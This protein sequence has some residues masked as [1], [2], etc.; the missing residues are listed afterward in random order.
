MLISELEKIINY[1]FNNKN[2]IN[3][4]LIHSSYVSKKNNPNNLNY[5]RLEFLGD[6]VLGLI[7]AEYFFKILPNAK[8]GVLN[9]YFQKS[10]NQ[11]FLAEYA[12]KINLSKFIKTQ[13][14]DNLKDNDSV[15]SDVVEAIIGAIFLDTNINNCKTFIISEIID[16][17]GFS[18]EPQKHA[19]SNLQEFCLKKFK[20]LP[21]YK[22]LDKSGMDHKPIFKVSASIKDLEVV[23]ATGSNL[24]NAEETAASRLLHILTHLNR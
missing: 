5:E 11:E 8:E 12:K 13:K 18:S 7:L 20:C 2:L 14:G 9:N 6:R 24:K 22:L 4:A 15:L 10:A 3:E 16:K 21:E 1:K 19:K 23:T 17:M